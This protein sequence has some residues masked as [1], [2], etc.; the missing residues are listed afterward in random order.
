MDINRYKVLEIYRYKATPSHYMFDILLSDNKI[1]TIAPNHYQGLIKGILCKGDIIS[2]S[3]NEEGFIEFMVLGDE[4]EYITEDGKYDKKTHY[5]PFLCD[6][7]PFA[8]NIPEILDV[9]INPFFTPKMGELTPVDKAL[10]Q[11]HFNKPLIGRVLHKTRIFSLYSSS[12]HPFLFI[13]IITS[14]RKHL[15]VFFWNETAL[16]CSWIKEGDIILINNYKHRNYNLTANSLVYNSMNELIYFSED[17]INVN[18]SDSVCKAELRNLE[19]GV[20]VI[21]PLDHITE[22]LSGIIVYLSIL[23]RKRGSVKEYL[24]YDDKIYEYYLIRIKTQNEKV[25]HIQLFY[26]SQDL[27]YKLNVGDHLCIKYLRPVE[28]FGFKYYISTIYTAY[29]LNPERMAYND[30]T[31]FNGIGFIPDNLQNL[32]QLREEKTEKIKKEKKGE[33]NL[34]IKDIN[35]IIETDFYHFIKEKETLVINETRK[36]IFSAIIFHFNIKGLKQSDNLPGE[37]EGIDYMKN[38][39]EERQSCDVI[40]IGMSDEDKISVSIFDN[41]FTSEAIG[42]DL[43]NLQRGN[44]YYFIVD[45]LRVSYDVILTNLS[46]IFKK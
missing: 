29:C 36:Y 21:S 23:M 22:E 1:Y 18:Y 39:S 34:I 44:E 7:I 33:L 46:R 10:M 13:A 25:E 4:E 35:T 16:T 27:F 30:N 15:T 2:I 41:L 40:Q 42:D 17:R 43:S 31:I 19:S 8:Q 3:K 24:S 38:G 5:M 45:V 6:V 32:E 12:K 28:R 11:K 20:N 14:G 37:L 26:N 9:S